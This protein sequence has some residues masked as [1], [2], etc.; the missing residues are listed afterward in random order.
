MKDVNGQ[1]WVRKCEQSEGHIW[2]FSVLSVLYFCKR[3]TALKKVI[4]NNIRHH[5]KTKE[6]SELKDKNV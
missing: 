3:K 4:K 6:M 2:E 5:S 1:N